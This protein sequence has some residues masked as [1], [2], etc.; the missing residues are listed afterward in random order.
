MAGAGKMVAQLPFH[1][2][3]NKNSNSSI[4][5]EPWLQIVWLPNPFQMLQPVMFGLNLEKGDMSIHAVFCQ[6]F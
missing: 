1:Q 2:S 3:W 5:Y 4:K 6:N